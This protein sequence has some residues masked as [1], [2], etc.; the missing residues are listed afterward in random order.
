MEIDI[1]T[2]FPG[3]FSGVFS[4][5]IIKIAL[6]NKLLKIRI[7][8]LRDFTE[9]KHRKVD[10]PPY[11]GGAGMVLRCE[12]LFAA[13]K[14]VNRE[15]RVVLLSPQGKVFNQSLAKKFL[16]KKKILLICGHYEG[17]DERIRKSL[18]D[19]EISIGD[20]I[21]SGGEPAAIVF[22]DV[23]ARLIP[24]VVGDYNSVKN[25]SFE[26]GLLDYPHY[27]KPRIFKKLRVPS[28]LLSGNHKKIE[29]WRNR[30]AFLNTKRKRPDLLDIKS[31]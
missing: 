18:V 26:E 3:M 24:G 7:H 31:K 10:A 28:V 20:Y 6:R 30:Q 22:V 21:L 19:D 15:H 25:E 9:D 29:Q 16:K 5:S 27:T 17:I 1:I 8:N 14:A 23:L 11:G 4:N 12:P 13:I 2:L